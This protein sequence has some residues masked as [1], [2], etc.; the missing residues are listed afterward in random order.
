MQTL[1]TFAEDGAGMQY[2]TE[3]YFSPNGRSIHKTG[4]EPDVV[5]ELEGS[6]DSSVRTPDP[7]NDNQLAAAMEEL[8]KR[9]RAAESEGN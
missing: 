6:Y 8:E 4:V 2:T 5:V 1:I 3:S 9:I 7:E